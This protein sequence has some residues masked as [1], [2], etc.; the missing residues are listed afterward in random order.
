MAAPDRT[1][2]SDGGASLEANLLDRLERQVAEL[3][4]LKGR[5]RSLESALAAERKARSEMASRLTA[6]RERVKKL[7]GELG[8]LGTDEKEVTRLREEL[9]RERQS[10]LGLGTQLE[11]AWT[12]LNSLKAAQGHGRGPFRRKR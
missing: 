5:L 2:G 12:Q 3:T 9:A 11:Q 6:E 10:A 4:E 1:R 8:S 7:E